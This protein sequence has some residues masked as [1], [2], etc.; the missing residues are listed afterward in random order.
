M[1][2]PGSS[3]TPTPL[4]YE[5]NVGVGQPSRANALQA[6]IMADKYILE[7]VQSSKNIIEAHYDDE[8][9][10]NNA[11][12]VPTSSEMTIMKNMC[13]YKDAHSNGEMNNKMGHIEHIL[14]IDLDNLM[15]RNTMQRKT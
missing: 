4:G 11:T 2:T 12:P 8:N 3:F 14:N 7:F 5:E 10:M 13:S 15:L 1:V 9:E 6:P